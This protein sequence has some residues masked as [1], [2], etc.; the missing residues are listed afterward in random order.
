MTHH[1]WYNL[2]SVLIFLDWYFPSTVMTHFRIDEKPVECVYAR[3]LLAVNDKLVYSCY[4]A[5]NS[6]ILCSMSW[7]LSPHTCV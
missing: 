1:L 6:F 5:C 3:V 4:G 2:V 7:I